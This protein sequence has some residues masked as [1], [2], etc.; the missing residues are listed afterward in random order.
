[1]NILLCCSAG[2]STSL[3]VT[4]MEAAAKARGLGGKIWAV[5]G[6][7]VRNNIDEADVLLLGPQVRYMLSSLKALADDKNVGIDVINPMHYG[8][9][10][11]EAVLD[12]AL[13]LKK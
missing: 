9:M 5:S 10:N 1:M 7:A 2:M 6:D 4:K 11:G 13:T 12:H 3:L 8:M